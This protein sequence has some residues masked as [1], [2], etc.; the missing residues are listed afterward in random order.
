M[1]SR[2]V[3]TR[4]EAR[5]IVMEL[6]SLTQKIEAI[7]SGKPLSDPRLTKVEHKR[8]ALQQERSE[9]EQLQQRAGIAESPQKISR[10][11]RSIQNLEDAIQQ[12]QR[13]FVQRRD[14]LRETASFIPHDTCQKFIK[15][16]RAEI[17]AF[18]EKYPLN[19]V[20]R[21]R[22][23]LNDLPAKLAEFE[24]LNQEAK[25]DD[26]L[27]EPYLKIGGLLHHILGE[28]YVL[29]AVSPASRVKTEFIRLL[30]D[31]LA[32]QNWDRKE[33]QQ[34]YAELLPTQK[35]WID[36]SVLRDQEQK[37]YDTALQALSAEI[38]K[39]ISNLVSN[40]VHKAMNKLHQAMQQLH[41][42]IQTH[43]QRDLK[44]HRRLIQRAT[45]LL[46]HPKDEEIRKNFI[47]LADHETNG[48]SSQNKLIASAVSIFA[49]AVLVVVG[50]LAFAPVTPFAIIPLVIGIGFFSKGRAKGCA[51]AIENI[52][53]AIQKVKCA[54]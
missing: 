31:L 33:L 7:K 11:R 6:S 3:H 15:I 49:S 19:Q 9:L 52:N 25:G 10:R 28:L 17:V 40:D 5:L 54:A 47:S 30:R 1:K 43:P 13:D 48:A 44:F 22:I 23:Y 39:P 14:E 29:P 26:E 35:Q 53:K 37:D 21:L 20:I 36:E 46:Q 4:E 32:E 34:A 12:I 27:I 16:I 8:S 38:A 2:L 50:F 51:N 41:A 45:K 42:A 24:K 18:E